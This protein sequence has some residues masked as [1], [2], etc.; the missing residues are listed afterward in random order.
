MSIPTP[1]ITDEHLA[2]SAAGAEVAPLIEPPSPHPDPD[3]L[4]PPGAEGEP[5]ISTCYSMALAL[6]ALVT[7]TVA[8][9]PRVH[10]WLADHA[11][12][13][14]AL[15][16]LHLAESVC[17]SGDDQDRFLDMARASALEV[18]AVLTLLAHR[19]VCSRRRRR[20][21]RDVTMRLVASLGRV[22]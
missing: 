6:D 5:R 14:S 8:D 16:V 7:H 22:E 1:E 20:E 21:A 15:L 19:G 3:T 18:D 10:A 17:R 13:A 4:L 2:A 12:R 9:V 11:Q